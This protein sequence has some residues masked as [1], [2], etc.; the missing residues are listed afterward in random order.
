MIPLPAAAVDT[1]FVPAQ[2]QAGA[3][4]AAPR[5]PALWNPQLQLARELIRNRHFERAIPMLE[6][7]REVDTAEVQNLL[8]YAHRKLGRMEPSRVHYERAL[9]VD[10]DHIPT[11]EYY[12]EWFVQMGQ[13][14]RARSHLARIERLC[15]QACEAYQDLKHAIDTGTPKEH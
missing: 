6:G 15:G 2:E 1:A 3:P 7:L 9:L 8:G 5:A 11:L 12:G 4:A 14:D 10:A 13:L